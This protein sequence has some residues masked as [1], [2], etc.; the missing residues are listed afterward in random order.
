MLD[1]TQTK[2]KNNLSKKI[3][4]LNDKDSYIT[5]LQFIINHNIK[6]TENSNGVFFNLKHLENSTIIELIDLVNQLSNK[7]KNNLNE[8]SLVVNNKL[9]D[10]L[11]DDNFN[12]HLNY[13]KYINNN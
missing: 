3:K 12:L 9:T 8:N 2:D 1:S 11:N 7:Q 6:Y 5:I 10:N 13:K 4:N